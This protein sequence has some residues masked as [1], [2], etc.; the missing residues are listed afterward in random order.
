MFQI[1]FGD[2]LLKALTVFSEVNGI[3]GRAEDRYA[4]IIEN[5][6]KLERCLPPIL[7]DDA[8]ELA[9]LLFR[10]DD[11]Q[12]VFRRERLKIEPVR[13]IV[14]GGNRLGVAVHHDRFDADIGKGECGVA[15]AIVKLDA[16]TDAVGAATE[17][18][19][20]LAVGRISL[21]SRFAAIARI[22]C[23]IHIR[24]FGCELGGARVDP[25]K[26]RRNVSRPS[27]ITHFLFC[28][29]AKRSEANVRKASGLEQAQ[30]FR[31]LGQA[32]CDNILLELHNLLDLLKEPGVILRDGADLLDRK[33]MTERLSVTRKRSGV[34]AA[35][36]ARKA[37]A[38]SS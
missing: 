31:I 28:A 17:D 19:D 13:G 37:F 16:L 29:A 27:E 1:E 7:H 20:L 36:A 14:V 32:A 35:R 5:A 18:D 33:A 21:A 34:G 10:T 30:S 22:I 12:N 26:D 6:C 11:F 4:F 25:L 3:I 2:Q 8:E 9:G 15:T 38:S 23:G 24:C